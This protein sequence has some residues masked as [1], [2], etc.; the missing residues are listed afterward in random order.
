MHVFCVL[1]TNFRRLMELTEAA[2]HAYC[3][4]V[5]LIEKEVAELGVSGGVPGSGVTA[6]HLYAHMGHS[7]TPSAC[8]AISFSSSILSEPISE[9]YPH[10]EPE[11]DS[12]GYEIVKLAT[13]DAMTRSDANKALGLD[14]N[15]VAG[16][17][18]KEDVDGSNAAAVVYGNASKHLNEIDEGNEA[19]TEDAAEPQGHPGHRRNRSRSNSTGSGSRRN[20]SN[21]SSCSRGGDSASDVDADDEDEKV[22]SGEK[23]PKIVPGQQQQQQQYPSACAVDVSGVDAAPAAAPLQPHAL[24]SQHDILSQHSS[25][26]T[27]ELSGGEALSTHSSYHTLADTSSPATPA[28]PPKVDATPPPPAS[29]GGSGAGSGRG[30]PTSATPKLRPIDKEKMI[31]SWVVE[32]QQQTQRLKSRTNVAANNA[33]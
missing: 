24:T 11:T 2:R 5:T 9:N 31:E 15:G 4:M 7:R 29:G 1:Q 21:K 32:A 19:D 28:A 25:C 6:P 23:E 12:R 20:S 26:K 18:A 30:S 27:L 8:S 33:E 10:S 16:G 14:A 17:V 13:K 3:E 22:V